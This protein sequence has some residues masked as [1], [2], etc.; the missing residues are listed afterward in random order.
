MRSYVSFFLGPNTSFIFTA[1]D[2]DLH[3]MK[4]YTLLLSATLLAFL[5]PYSALAWGNKGHAIVA[6]VAFSLLDNGT[7]EKVRKALGT[8][9]IEEAANWM[10]NI[11]RDHRYD[12]MRSWHYL[13]LDK[14]MQ[15]QHTSED[16]IVNA[17]NKAIGELEHKGRLDDSEI[18]LDLLIVFHLVG[19][20]AMPLH[21]GYGE[22]KGGN[23]VEVTYEGH[24]A[25]LHQVW[26][27]RII[28]SEGITTEDCVA[29]YRRM[30]KRDI[31]QNKVI[32]VVEWI[33]EPR[34]MLGSVYNLPP[35]NNIDQAYIDRSKKIIE[36]QLTIAG[37][38]LAAVL[39][40][41]F[42]S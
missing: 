25:N 32:N 1:F 27:S 14:G 15:Y 42:K 8:M 18:R 4:K 9:T 26:D 36:Q 20:M 10:D 37:I 11:R 33:K 34:S 38:R 31:D 13:N 41:V 7:K 17:L 29:Y 23:T 40:Q 12:Y 35:D 5:L 3:P 2:I 30:S 24:R 19:D 16:N 22:D 28:E 39:E 6:E 21:V